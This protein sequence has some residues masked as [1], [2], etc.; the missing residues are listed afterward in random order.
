MVA[1]PL[2]W[3]TRNGNIS[4][5]VAEESVRFLLKFIGEDPTRDGLVNTPR[6]VA[7]AWCEMTTGYDVDIEELLSVQFEQNGG[8]HYGGI[9]I[10]RGIPFASLCEHHI[11]PFT[12][13]ADVAYIPG[14]SGRIVGLSKLARLVDAFAKRLQ[15]Q[16]RMTVQIVEALVENLSPKG[17][18]CV[19]RANHTCMSLRGV[20][21]EAG[22]MVTSE[23]RGLFFDDLRARGELMALLG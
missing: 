13:T 10:L 1:N 11:L 14:E 19:I 23:L 2:A 18:A 9:V 12:G 21:K 6:R 4:Q 15:V 8:G 22:G 17:A 3:H 16:E 5:H 20:E 7:K